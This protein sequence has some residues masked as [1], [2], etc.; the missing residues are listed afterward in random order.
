MRPG[1]SWTFCT[2]ATLSEEFKD[3]DPDQYNF[4][5]AC[6]ML[7]QESQTRCW[8]ACI[9]LTGIFLFLFITSACKRQFRQHQVRSLA[10][11]QVIKTFYTQQLLIYLTHVPVNEY[12]WFHR[13]LFHCQL[14]AAF[15]M[16]GSAQAGYLFCQIWILWFPYS[17]NT[18][19][20]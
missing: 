4:S 3:S 5:S 2:K 19:L 6:S 17:P 11:V 13:V 18:S 10:K 1:F 7:L 20:N 12:M 16:Y 15:I 14:I 8:N 9:K